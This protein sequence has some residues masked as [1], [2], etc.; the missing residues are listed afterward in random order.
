MIA[1]AKEH[2]CDVGHGQ[3]DEAYRSAESGYR[4]GKQRRREKEQSARA[5]DI[6]PHGHGVLLAEEQQVERFDSPYG[7]QQSDND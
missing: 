4:S 7:Q 2:P 1:V 3:P 5:A 6:Q